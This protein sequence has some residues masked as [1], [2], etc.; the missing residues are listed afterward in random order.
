[1]GTAKLGDGEKRGRMR[2][3]PAEWLSKPMGMRRETVSAHDSAQGSKAGI[4]RE[5]SQGARAAGAL[6][7]R[8]A[9]LSILERKAAR[10]T[11]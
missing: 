2:H 9:A 1:M 6:L 3:R 5:Q 10:D 7:E 4:G 11:N 8:K